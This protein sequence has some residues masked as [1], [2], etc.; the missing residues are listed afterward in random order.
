MLKKTCS[1][2]QIY[3]ANLC[4]GVDFV[5]AKNWMAMR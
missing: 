5:Y 3:G 4:K 1:L 2:L